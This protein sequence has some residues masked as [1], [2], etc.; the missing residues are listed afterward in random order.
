MRDEYHVPGESPEGDAYPS[1][2]S[3]YEDAGPVQDR[4]AMPEEDE[5]A[6]VYVRHEAPWVGFGGGQPASDPEGFASALAPA[7]P[8]SSEPEFTYLVRPRRRGREAVAAG[9]TA[10][11]IL[12]AVWFLPGLL[13]P[14][15]EKGRVA[16]YALFAVGGSAL[17]FVLWRTWRWARGR[18]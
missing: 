14:A 17:L 7:A 8:P 6:D 5:V 12:V 16:A 10:G 15:T 18:E 3:P 2:G 1:D 11:I 13:S 4:Y 9:V